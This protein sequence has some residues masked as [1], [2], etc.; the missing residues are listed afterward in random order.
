MLLKKDTTLCGLDCVI[1]SASL[2]LLDT[3]AAYDVQLFPILENNEVGTLGEEERL[4]H[5]K[6]DGDLVFPRII[7]SFSRLRWMKRLPSKFRLH[8]EV[9]LARG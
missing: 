7:F 2:Y 5:L 3:L 4:F 8:V 1:R 6:I 9:L